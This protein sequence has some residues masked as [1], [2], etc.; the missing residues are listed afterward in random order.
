MSASRRPSW[1]PGEL[2]APSQLPQGDAGGVADDITGTRP[3]RRGL[4]HQRSH[5]V[6]G[7]PGPQVLGPG[8]DQGPGLVERLDPLGAG[9]ALGDHQ[10]AD[11]LDGAIAAPGRAARPAGLSRPGGAD[12]VERV[13]LALT[14]AVLPVG[15]VH[16]DDPDAGRGDVAGQAGAVAAGPFDPDQAHRPEPRQPVQ[17]TCIA[18]RGGRELPDAKQPADGVERGGDVRAG[19]GIHPAGD[20]VSLYDGHSH[21]FPVV[22][23][24]HAP[25]GRRT[26]ETPASDP[27][28]ADQTGYAGGCQKNL[29]PGRQIV[30][31]DS[32]SG[33]SR[34]GGQAG[35]Q[36]SDLTPAPG[37]NHGSRAG[38]TTHSLPADSGRGWLA[39]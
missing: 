1:P 35:T 15:P 3:Q 37:Q 10:R 26:W 12:R 6:P 31:Q 7:E 11:R 32:P 36:A 8:Q 4:G 21:P 16:L 17:Q 14:A 30:S 29:G 25:A 13:G 5:G 39:G 23:G 22:E 38:S 19:M 9:A 33:V 20:G 24:W 27:G 18:G 28:Q 34:F 2:R